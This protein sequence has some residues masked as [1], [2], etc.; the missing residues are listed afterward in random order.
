[1]LKRYGLWF[2]V[3]LVGVRVVRTRVRVKFKVRVRVRVTI[4]IRVRAYYQLGTGL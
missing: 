1:M 2:M 3:Q 4:R